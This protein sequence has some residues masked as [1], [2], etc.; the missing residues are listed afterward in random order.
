[1]YALCLAEITNP[2]IVNSLGV[3]FSQVHG[4]PHNGFNLVFVVGVI[5]AQDDAIGLPVAVRASVAIVN[6]SVR[7]HIE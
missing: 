4:L 1:M 5:T 6:Q 2:I 7:V 3:V